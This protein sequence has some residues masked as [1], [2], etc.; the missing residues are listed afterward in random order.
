M[1][2]EQ[3]RSYLDEQFKDAFS[4]CAPSEKSQWVD[5]RVTFIETKNRPGEEVHWHLT[6]E[7]EDSD[8]VYDIAVP[9]DPVGMVNLLNH[10][11][12][13]TW[14]DFDSF[15]AVLM[16]AIR[17][18]V[19]KEKDAE[20]EKVT[21]K[22]CVHVT[23][24]DAIESILK[25][26]L[27]PSIGPLSKKL[28]KSPGIFMFPSWD[29]MMDANWLFD[30]SWPHA[31]EPALLCVNTEGMYFSGAIGYEVVFRE[32]IDP[33]R[34]TVIA[35]GEDNW[36]AAKFMFKH[37]G[38]QIESGFHGVLNSQSRSNYAFGESPR[39]H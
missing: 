13:K 8:V 35:P 38:G 18:I 1:N 3:A 6:S 16:P 21:I 28:E 19:T 34:I 9:R 7:P 36:D 20:C 15:L 14:I 5:G 22:A 31:S 10:M 2:S 11:K 25:N 30:E 37:L 27:L 12:T 26:G 24:A 4:A 29:D 33:D 17:E 32:K 23:S 39:Q